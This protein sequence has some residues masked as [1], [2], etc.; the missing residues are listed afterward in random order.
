MNLYPKSW[1]EA[2]A[3]SLQSLRN[4]THYPHLR[5]MADGMVWI[6]LA[7]LTFWNLGP[8]NL[9]G[10]GFLAGLF[11]QHP[12]L[13]VAIL[14]GGIWAL[15]VTGRVLGAV[16]HVSLDYLDVGISKKLQGLEDKK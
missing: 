9:A 2:P 15:V 13:G 12:V 5:A 3:P 6:L 16:L 7:V 4:K 14:A 11:W 8:G 1:K 10:W